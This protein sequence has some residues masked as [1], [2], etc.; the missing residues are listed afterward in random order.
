MKTYR[1]LIAGL[2]LFAACAALESS[3]GPSVNVTAT[4]SPLDLPRGDTA[5]I[6]V[7]VRNVGDREIEVMAQQCN[8]DFYISDEDG[9][10]YIPAELVYCTLELKAP[11]K[12]APGASWNLEAFTTGRV[13]PQGSQ[14]E[15]V[16][17]AAGTYRIRPS[18]AIRSGDEQAVVVSADP[19]Y[20]TFR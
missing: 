11:V 13:V 17:L 18:I 19:A 6:N 12:L 3:G 7:T 16:L 5:R 14:S 1:L 10:A 20:V 8:N 9:N 15:P 2:P 4:T